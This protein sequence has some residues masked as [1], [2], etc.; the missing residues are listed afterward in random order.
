IA[1]AAL[2]RAVRSGSFRRCA[3]TTFVSSRTLPAVFID[4]LATFLNNSFQL[5]GFFR[6]ECSGRAGED[7]LA[8]FL[9]DPLEP[10]HEVGGNFQPVRRQ[11]LQVLDDVFE[12]AHNSYGTPA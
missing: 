4:L 5:V 7:R 9:A 1:G 8:L 6:R 11:R 12:R 3:T 10:V 2:K